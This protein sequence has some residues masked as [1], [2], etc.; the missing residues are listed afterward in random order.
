MSLISSHVDTLFGSMLGLHW[1]FIGTT[2]ANR[3]GKSMGNN[4]NNNNYQLMRLNEVDKFPCRFFV[5]F[6]RH[7]ES[8]NN[9]DNN[10]NYQLMRLISSHV[11]SSFGTIDMGRM[12]TATTTFN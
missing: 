2:L 10:N 4:I 9:N 6:N 5:W 1:D 3:H 12:T 7:V 11:E 8:D